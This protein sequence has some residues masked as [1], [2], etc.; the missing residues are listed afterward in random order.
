MAAEGT[1]GEGGNTERQD[2]SKSQIKMKLGYVSAV[3]INKN[4][5]SEILAPE[6]QHTD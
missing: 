6:G 3:Q 1:R 4:Q 5:E 2:V